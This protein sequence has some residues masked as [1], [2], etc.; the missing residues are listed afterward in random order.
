MFP[1]SKMDASQHWQSYQLGAC[2]QQPCLLSNE[3]AMAQ[4]PNCQMA[5]SSVPPTPD[6][7]EVWMRGPNQ[8]VQMQPQP[9]FEAPWPVASTMEAAPQLVI[10]VPVCTTD[11]SLSSS[12]A[13]ATD[14]SL[15]CLP[16]VWQQVPPC[17]PANYTDFNYALPP[18]SFTP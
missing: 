2:A 3:V 12:S 13:C 11:V 15:P 6:M 5:A 18:Q 8:M 17:R 4:W 9:M 7:G 14:A 10:L 16:A 1:A